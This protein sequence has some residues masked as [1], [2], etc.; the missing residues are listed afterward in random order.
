[1]DMKVK[2]LVIKPRRLG[3]RGQVYNDN[4]EAG[5]GLNGGDLLL[6]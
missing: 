4:H 3:F 6:P 2:A 5:E 1:M